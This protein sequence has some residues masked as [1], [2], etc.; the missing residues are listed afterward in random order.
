MRKILLILFMSV[1]GFTSQNL[2]GQVTTSS[3]SGTVVDEQGAGIPGATVLAVHTPSGT[4]YGAT[5][6]EDGRFT[7]LGMRVGGP[8]T[9]TVSSVG[10][11]DKT[12]ENIFLEL[13]Q[14]YNLE[15]NL[16]GEETTLNEVQVIAK[17]DAVMNSDKT[18]AGTNISNRQI[19][20]LP[21]L[22][23]SFE[24]FTRL[25]PQASGLSF[26]GR[27]SGFNNITI[28]GALFNNV[29]GLSSTI[30]G[31]ANAQPI[32]LDAI[33]QIQV[34]IAPYDVRQGAFTGA[35]INAVTRSGTNEFQGSVYYFFRNDGL[36]GK[37]ISQVENKVSPFSLYNVGFR[38][39]GPIIKNKLFFFANYESERRTDPVTF[40]AARP[41]EG[42]VGGT[43]NVSQVLASDLDNL[44]NFLRNQYGY[45]AG[46]YEGYSMPS[47]SD[48]ATFKL[49]WNISKNHKF[50]IKYNYLSSV[51]EVF[52]SNSGAIGG[53]RSPSLNG[54]PFRSANYEINNNMHSL[55]AELN[56][57]FGTKISNNF[58]IG[59]T[60]L[61]DFRN[62]MSPVQTAGP[63]AGKVM[64]FTEI[65]NGSGQVLTTFGYEPFTFNNQLK[66]NIFQVSNN[67]TF[68]QGKH[69]ITIGTYNEFYRFQNGFAPNYV[70]MF[71]FRSL[72]E[73]Y[74]SANNGTRNVNQYRYRSSALPDGR[75]P[76]A[77]ISAA[78]LGFYIQDEFEVN[79]KFKLTGGLRVDIPIISSNDIQTNENVLNNMRFRDNL[80]INTGKL[81]NASVLWSPRVGFNWDVKGDKTLQLRG[82][83]G[84]F[85]GRVPYVWISNQASN[86]G[87]QFNVIEPVRGNTN[88]DVNNSIP[89]VS[90]NTNPDAFRNTFSAA[91]NF[92]LAV[93]DGNFKFPQIWRTNVAVDKVF[94]GGW[95]VSLDL[96]FT[97]DINAVYHQ[98]VNLPEATRQLVHT[99]SGNLDPRPTYFA[100]NT[101]TVNDRINP[102]V[103]DAILMRN[104]NQGYSY[105]ATLQ[106]Q[107]NISENTFFSVAY[108]YSDARSVND[109]GSI[110]Q[111][112]WRD[113]QISGDPNA[114]TL[115]FSNFLTRHR[116]VMNGSHRQTWG[117]WGST[118]ISAFYS[119]SPNNRFSYVY[120]GDVNGDGQ[121]AN[122]LMYVPRNAG[123][124][125]LIP[126][127]GAVVWSPAQQWTMLDA[128]IAQDPYLNSRRGQYAERNGLE[129][130]WLGRLDLRILQDF[131]VKAGK[132]KNTLQVSFD[133]FN[134]L[135]F[136][137]S[138]WGV[139]KVI[140]RN[141]PL[142]FT[143]YNT[144]TGQPQFQFR[145]LT[146]ATPLT[147]TFRDDTNIASRWQMQ[148]GI[149]YIFN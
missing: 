20:R 147:T 49:D 68:Y 104:T 56:S 106:V 146:G 139:A 130:R 125:E 45:E 4:Q 65:A 66:T 71:G 149:R 78:Q 112:I 53:T 127:T 33:D 116:I 134:F 118:T 35:G 44:R 43:G 131:Y 76:F 32:S 123:E 88:V 135:N 102:T 12:Q 93:T 119:A 115:S 79:K 82:G 109:G 126:T 122:D 141:N 99:G 107:K 128:Y 69:T 54:L 60:A 55:I 83:T 63:N 1:V 87:V 90:Y 30:G 64:P 29:F 94:K 52:P 140:N 50:N 91:P 31:Q 110:A 10:S 74:N 21:T 46:E 70:G 77:N 28:D 92:N 23:R 61:R 113:R 2:L 89:F 13:G 72:T 80:Q 136:V 47:N 75:F 103:T 58:T 57:T 59:F 97:K 7:I 51:R 9:V 120:N 3:M 132:T 148:I 117:K 8:Y 26:G 101:F 143:G 16:K 73:F 85:T 114:A 14:N 108:N 48:K 84:V 19:T 42:L 86:N 62:A 96:A 41:S 39:G 22:N 129:G 121:N 40:V 67:T 124:I 145:P 142:S 34:S 100:P 25:T 144:V 105:F 98:Q 36:T 38:V 37:Y 27:S 137:N 6:Q 138:N 133:V 17:Q 11:A 15:I 18:G 111:S 81:Q 95:V 5:T 24:D